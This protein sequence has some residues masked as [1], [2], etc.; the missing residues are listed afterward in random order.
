M[1]D[2]G[3]KNGNWHLDAFLDTRQPIWNWEIL[4][5]DWAELSDKIVH[6]FVLKMALPRKLKDVNATTYQRYA[7]WNVNVFR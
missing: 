6:L 3:V 4:E 1:H 5:Y 2:F 7:W